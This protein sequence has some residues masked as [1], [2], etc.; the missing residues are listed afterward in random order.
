MKAY[1]ALELYGRGGDLLY[2]RKKPVES[3]LYNWTKALYGLLYSTC[4]S[5]AVTLKDTGGSDRSYPYLWDV[6]YEIFKFRS[7][8][9]DTR[10]GILVGNGTATVTL[11]DYKLAS[12]I[13]HGTSAGRLYYHETKTKHYTNGDRSY[14]EVSRLLVNDSG[15]SV[16][17]SEVGLAFHEYNYSYGRV[18]FLILR[19]LVDPAITVEPEQLL[20]VRYVFEFLL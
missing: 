8:I 2:E 7:G 19:D 1:L 15:S 4:R 5:R 3:F 12:L 18:Y 6:G 11:D 9:G 14:L 10:Y 13:Q 20:Q 17:V 16:T